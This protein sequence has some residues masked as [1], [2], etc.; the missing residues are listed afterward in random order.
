MFNGL[1]L[2]TVTCQV[3][4]QRKNCCVA[5]TR[6]NCFEVR[7]QEEGQSDESWLLILLNIFKSMLETI[8]DEVYV[9]VY[10]TGR[11]TV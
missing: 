2:S 8:L 10:C 5:A 3:S 6:S 7:S 4:K 11:Y 9:P 1:A